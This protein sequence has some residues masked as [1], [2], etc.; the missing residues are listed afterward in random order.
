MM[1]G[2]GG[3]GVA[4]WHCSSIAQPLLMAITPV[5]GTSAYRPSCSALAMPVLTG[6]FIMT[7]AIKALGKA[8]LITT[9]LATSAAAAAQPA[10]APPKPSGPERPAANQV[11]VTGN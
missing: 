8:S 9:F 7:I 11:T 3:G 5:P 6:D 4:E 1:R 10:S 2:P